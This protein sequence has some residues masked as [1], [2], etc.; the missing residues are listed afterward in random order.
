[1]DFEGTLRFDG[2]TIPARVAP[3][4]LDLATPAFQTRQGWS[5]A[6]AKLSLHKDDVKIVRPYR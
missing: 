3:I 6:S 5:S 2:D 4:T 1:M